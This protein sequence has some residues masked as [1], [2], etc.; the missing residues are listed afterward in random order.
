METLSE[1]GWVLLTSP[2]LWLTIIM[3]I[4]LARYRVRAERRVFRMAI[5]PRW[6][7]VRYFIGHGLLAGLGISCVTLLLGVAVNLEWWLVYQIIAIIALMVIGHRL[8]ATT[9]LL[10]SA[11]VYWGLPLIWP[12]YQSADTNQL[13]AE[14]L[15]VIGLVAFATGWLQRKDAGKLTTPNVIE[16]QRG[17]LTAIFTSRQVYLA[18]VFFLVPGTLNLPDWTFW[19]VLHIGQTTYSIVI[20]PLLL[21]FSFKA[22]QVLMSVLV[23][24]SVKRQIQLGVLSLIL[25]LISVVAP[26]FAIWAV[27]IALLGGFVLQWRLGKL[28]AGEKRLYFTKPYQGVRVLGVQTATPAAKMQLTVGDVIVECNGLPVSNNENFYQAIQSQP[29]Y[30]HLKV[31]DLQGEYRITESAVFADAPHELGVILFPEN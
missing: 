15:I 17:R 21:G 28:K 12:Q 5:N 26:Q 8:N 30:C 23:Q 7:E 27:M 6:S 13:L 14:L 20:L 25:G 16:S 29:T 10:V 31:Q 19:P 11:V 3:A 9:I 1:I 4:G 2:L 24:R 22:V 18:P